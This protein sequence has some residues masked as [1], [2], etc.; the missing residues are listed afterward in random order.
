MKDI[1]FTAMAVWAFVATAGW[2]SGYARAADLEKK[3]LAL[4]NVRK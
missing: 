2:Y 3:L 4:L 1:V